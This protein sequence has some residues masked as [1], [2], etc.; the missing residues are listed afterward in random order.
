M[1]RLKEFLANDLVERALKTFV[2]AFVSVLIIGGFKLDKA[3]LVA[4][5]AAGISAVWNYWKT[6]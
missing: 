3:T 5:G 1:E 4:A 2:Q 6:T